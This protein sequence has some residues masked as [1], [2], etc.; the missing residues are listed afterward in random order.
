MEKELILNPGEAILLFDGSNYSELAME[1]L[2]NISNKV[3]ELVREEKTAAE[4]I[5]SNPH[6]YIAMFTEPMTYFTRRHM[7]AGYR[8]FLESVRTMN[9]P[10][11]IYSTQSESSSDK[12]YGIEE[13]DLVKGR[14][15]DGFVN[16]D[17]PDEKEQVLSILEKIANK[18]QIHLR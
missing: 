17:H 6:S 4:S 18:N 14:H 2:A 5:K 9:L 15:Y 1:H 7:R 3:V 16:K 11:I 12:G 10:V 8:E 13:W